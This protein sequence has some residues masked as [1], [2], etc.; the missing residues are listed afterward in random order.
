MLETL[1]LKR[2]WISQN[3]VVAALWL[4]VC[5]AARSQSVELGEK[6]FRINCMACHALEAGKNRLGPSLAS[7]LGS[8]AGAV[9]GFSYSAANRQAQIIWDDTTLEDFLEEPKAV[10][11]GTSMVFSGLK[12]EGDRKA[13][14]LYLKS[15]GG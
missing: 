13:L 10:M 5:L 4:S 7:L 8:K 1:H 12:N 6:V 14:I 3:A 2:R 15:N 9:A 11:P